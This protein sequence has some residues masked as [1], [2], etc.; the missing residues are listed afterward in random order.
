M[1]E[2]AGHSSGDHATSHCGAVHLNRRCARWGAYSA[3]WVRHRQHRSVNF[4][5]PAL[6]CTA[7]GRYLDCTYPVR[8]PPCPIWRQQSSTHVLGSTEEHCADRGFDGQLST[9][10]RILRVLWQQIQRLSHGKLNVW[11]YYGPYVSNQGCSTSTVKCTRKRW[12]TM[13]WWQRSTTHCA[14]LTRRMDC[15]RV[16]K[17]RVLFDKSK[18]T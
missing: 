16:D 1:V 6:G 14:P 3:S 17:T 7:R 13:K 11:H 12:K 10:R 15:S 4:A 5:G 9:S 18:C 8:L 2:R